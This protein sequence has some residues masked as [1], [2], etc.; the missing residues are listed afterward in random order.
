MV[1]QR[2][3]IKAEQTGI[4]F[5]FIWSEYL[6]KGRNELSISQS[7]AAAIE[8]SSWIRRMFEAGARLRASGRTVYDFSLGNPDVR[9]PAALKS[10]LIE[11]AARDE[12]GIHGYM[13][14]AGLSSVREQVAVKASQEQSTPIPADNILM[15]CGAGG[16]LN[17]AIKTLVNPG[18]TILVQAPYFMEYRFYAEN[19]GAGIHAVAPTADFG[20]NI[21]GIRDAITEKTAAV[22]INSPNNPSGRVYTESELD[23]LAAALNDAAGRTGRTV[24]LISDEPYRK[25]VYPPASVPPTMVGYQNTIVCTSYSKELSIPGERIGYLAVHPSAEGAR[26]IVEGAVLCNRVLGYVNAPALMQRVVARVVHDSVDVDVYRNRRDLL[27]TEL[28][29]QGYE[30]TVPDGAFY[31]F[32]AAPGRDDMEF[33]KRLQSYGILAVPGSGFGTPGFFRISFCVDESVIAGAFE[34]FERA[35]NEH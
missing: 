4:V 35:L 20:L 9:P 10:A 21:A 17:V 5:L 30:L 1:N 18:D 29:R 22:V 7:V 34:G 3:L 6:C 11:E 19:H 15:T 25:L 27:C 23:E 2:R 26:Q 24:Y 14:N 33:V 32:P 31:A 16:A 12:P 8:N 13:P 28:L